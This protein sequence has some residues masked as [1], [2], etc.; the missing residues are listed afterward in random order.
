VK[1]VDKNTLGESVQNWYIMI[2]ESPDGTRTVSFHWLFELMVNLKI[3]E[4]PKINTLDVFGKRR[5]Q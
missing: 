4:Y 2:S 5:T 1:I 3:K